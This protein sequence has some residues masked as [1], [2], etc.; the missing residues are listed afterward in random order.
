MIINNNFK[1]A[2]IEVNSLLQ[3][4]MPIILNFTAPISSG[5]FIQISRPVSMIF[6]KEDIKRGCIIFPEK[7]SLVWFIEDPL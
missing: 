1:R 7:Y 5:T 6:R 4:D 2:I 3:M